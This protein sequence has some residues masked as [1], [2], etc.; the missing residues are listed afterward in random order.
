MGHNVSDISDKIG[1]F[2]P[3]H[4][5]QYHGR[6]LSELL[7]DPNRSFIMRGTVPPGGESQR[8]RTG[9][10]ILLD[11]YCSNEYREYLYHYIESN[12]MGDLILEDYNEEL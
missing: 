12:G 7:D 3:T 6:I 10:L 9:W 11:I 1:V 8:S 2:T 4:P 5:I